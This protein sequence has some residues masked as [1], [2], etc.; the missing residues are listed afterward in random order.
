M[1]RW[2]LTQKTAVMTCPVPRPACPQ[3][4]AT[5]IRWL[6]FT[7]TFNGFDSFQCEA[8]GKSWTPSHDEK[9]TA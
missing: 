5:S 3:C 4:G 1:A 6:E 7:S 9:M 2:A 8:C